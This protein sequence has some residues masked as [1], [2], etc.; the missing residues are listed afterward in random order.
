MQF[1]LT[2]L[3]ALVTVS[4][5]ALAQNVNYRGY[6]SMQASLSRA[7]ALH[8]DVHSEGGVV[9]C[10][11][12]P[13]GFSFSAQSD[14]LPAGTEGQGYTGGGCRKFASGRNWPVGLSICTAP[15]DPDRNTPLF[16]T[17]HGRVFFFLSFPFLSFLVN[18]YAV[19]QYLC[20]A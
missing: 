2:S 15:F 9:C 5:S 4:T 10:S 18:V 8:S 3:I 19:Y 16:R 17:R 13:T 20:V 12:L 6:A 7:V 1:K 11:D 14:S